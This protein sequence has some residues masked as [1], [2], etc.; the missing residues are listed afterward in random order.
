MAHQMAHGK[1]VFI[2]GGFTRTSGNFCRASTASLPAT[3]TNPRADRSCYNA[4]QKGL[5]CIRC[6]AVGI[7]LSI[8]RIERLAI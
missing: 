1:R 5:A 8:R 2:S 6:V 7:P 3:Q 4:E